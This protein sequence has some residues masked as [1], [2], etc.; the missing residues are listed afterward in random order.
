M[1]NFHSEKPPSVDDIVDALLDF[2]TYHSRIECER[3]YAELVNRD[4]Y[5]YGSGKAVQEQPPEYWHDMSVMRWLNLWR[6]HVLPL[7]QQ[8]LPQVSVFDQI[9]EGKGFGTMMVQKDK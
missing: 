4:N 3:M 9:R 7:A 5:G 6:V 8:S 1:I 2:G